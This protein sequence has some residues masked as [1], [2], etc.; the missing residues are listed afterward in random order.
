VDI[1]DLAQALNAAA[2]R[3]E[4]GRLQELRA[5]L[6]SLSRPGRPTIFDRRTIH[7]GYAFHVGGRKE[8]QFNIGHESLPAGRILR[9]GVAFSLELSQSLPTI[10]PLLPKIARFNQYLRSRPEDFPGFR[11]WA[12]DKRL[13]R[14]PE[15]GVAPID[16]DLAKPGTF[17]ML[18]RHV[19]EA[20]VDVDA[21]LMDFDRLL[22]LYAYVEGD[23]TQHVDPA[24][25]V[26]R[27]GCPEFVSVAKAVRPEQRVDVALRH[28]ALQKALYSCLITET[29]PSDVSIEHQLDIGLRVDAAVREGK[30]LTFY[31]LKV[32]PS[33]QACIRP[34]I[35]QLLEY[36]HWPSA[37]RAEELIVVGECVPDADDRAYLHL[38]RRS[39]SIP[40]WYRQITLAPSML[41]PRV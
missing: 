20:D 32:A 41:G 28:K 16:S 3:F 19:P 21:I 5:R 1:A 36:A 39:F 4:I 24:P 22:P 14:R 30:R 11:M 15:H 25:V 37:K 38:L 9:H 27:P 35:G 34:A 10:E 33:V 23:G 6:R 7:P 8:L 12:F 13:G 18:G 31:E 2:P 29:D 26:F 40:I 17:I